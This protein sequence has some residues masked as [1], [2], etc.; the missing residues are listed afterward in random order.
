MP[1]QFLGQAFLLHSFRHCFRRK[2]FHVKGSVSG[3]LFR[4]GRWVWQDC[5][6]LVFRI[7]IGLF[8]RFLV[9]RFLVCFDGIR[10]FG[11]WIV[12][13]GIGC[14]L[15]CFLDKQYLSVFRVHL[16]K[17]QKN[18]LLVRT[19]HKQLVRSRMC[20]YTEG[21]RFSAFFLGWFVRSGRRRAP[22]FNGFGL[23]L[24]FTA[25]KYLYYVLDWN[26]NFLFEH[27]FRYSRLWLNIGSSIVALDLISCFDE[28]RWSKR[29]KSFRERNGCVYTG[30]TTHASPSKIA[31]LW[32]K[33]Q[34]GIVLLGATDGWISSER[35][36]KGCIFVFP[37]PLSHGARHF[38]CMLLL[39]GDAIAF[40]GWWFLATPKPLYKSERKEKVRME[41]V[42]LYRRDT[43]SHHFFI[44]TYAWDR[45]II[46]C[47]V[48]VGKGT[49]HC[50]RLSSVNYVI[51]P[52]D[53][54][55]GSR[56]R[57]RGY[58]CV[59]GP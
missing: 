52:R 59:D 9:R 7:Q 12:A 55:K 32:N 35:R 33:H 20:C 28:N 8:F 10:F 27:W 5:H 16:Q 26:S 2:R 58:C 13:L 21:G 6:F 48:G 45:E 30:F 43:L 3:R 14:L 25:G 53:K 39:P 22:P 44:V 34:F 1:F 41:A 37:V 15:F 46:R 36:R 54:S 47:E 50:S 24:D 29:R 18:Q 40:A 42:K 57:K 11:L 56:R 31:V 4:Y 17:G 23:S 51:V 19:I 49:K 38:F